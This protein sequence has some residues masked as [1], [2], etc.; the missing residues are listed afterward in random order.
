MNYNNKSFGNNNL[1]NSYQNFQKNNMPFKN[2]SLLHNNPQFQNTINNTSRNNMVTLQN[3]M[4]QLKKAQ[5]LKRL[6]RLNDINKVF[7]PKLIHESVIQPIKIE[8][9]NS[10][11]IVKMYEEMQISFEPTK[12][13]FWKSRTNQPY[14][15]VLSNV[16][17]QEDYKRDLKNDPK[18][19]IVY[20]TTDADKIGLMGEFGE[21]MNLLEKHNNE[22]KIIYS[23]SKET[24]YKEKFAYDNKYKFRIK[25][26]PKDFKGLKQDKINYYKKEQGKLE[27]NKKK[28]D[29]ILESLLSKGILSEDERKE[30]EENENKE[31]N[32]NDLENDIKTKL[33]A[34]EY[35]KMERDVLKQLNNK[36]QKEIDSNNDSEDEDD[37]EDE[38]R[39]NNSN[40]ANNK[41]TVK[42]KS[43]I[44]SKNDN[45]EKQQVGIISD[46]IKEKYKNRQKK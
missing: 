40:E 22:L 38:N 24:E 17:K 21:L 45:N 7:D 32:V 31:I 8:K 23:A 9:G 43:K 11:E 37:H 6:E 14:K 16:L 5:E 29:D 2:N 42:I 35:A 4:M 34:D 36:D 41:K 10:Q 20:K 46:E 28:V 33:G 25:Y 30:L 15:N 26:D 13:E 1:L 27:K 12:E 3:H 39:D 44:V 18:N 19:L